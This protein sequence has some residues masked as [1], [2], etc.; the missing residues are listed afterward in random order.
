MDGDKLQIVSTSNADAPVTQVL[1]PFLTINVWGRAYYLSCQ[2]KGVDYVNAII[3]KPLNWEWVRE[4]DGLMVFERPSIPIA[5][6]RSPTR[7]RSDGCVFQ[8]RTALKSVESQC[9]K[10][11]AADEFAKLLGTDLSEPY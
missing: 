7:Q 9:A 8:Q 2:Y 11:I 4:N 5:G 6:N 3:D 10:P 1:T